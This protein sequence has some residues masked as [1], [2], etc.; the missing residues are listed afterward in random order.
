[1]FE[2]FIGRDLVQRRVKDQF[3]TAT[4][5][6]GPDAERKRQSL[7][8]GGPAFVVRRFASPRSAA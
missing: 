2:L 3:E 1:M 5:R 7:R 6:T 4:V 8:R